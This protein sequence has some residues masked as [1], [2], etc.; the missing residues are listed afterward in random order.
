VT[1][2]EEEEETTAP[3]LATFPCPTCL[4]PVT[5]K[6]TGERIA[7]RETAVGDS[8]QRVPCTTCEGACYVLRDVYERHTPSQRS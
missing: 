1:D 8:A 6:P 2:F 3:D 5:G 7:L 4:D